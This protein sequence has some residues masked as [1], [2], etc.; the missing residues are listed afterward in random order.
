MKT[1]DPISPE[2]MTPDAI[3]G[4]RKLLGSI[5]GEALGGLIRWRFERSVKDLLAT[6]AGN[7]DAVNAALTRAQS[8][9][10]IYQWFCDLA[11]HEV[12]EEAAKEEESSDG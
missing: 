5:V 7:R 4:V 6:D 2:D 1:F 10:Q 12:T 9:E 8:D 11:A 3:I